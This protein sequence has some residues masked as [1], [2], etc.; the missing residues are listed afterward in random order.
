[1]ERGR[2]PYEQAFQGVL[3]II[4]VILVGCFA[5]R[6]WCMLLGDAGVLEAF[7]PSTSASTVFGSG[8]G[9]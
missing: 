3:E 1:L 6:A 8:P 4:M 7:G 2:T 5:A 9:D